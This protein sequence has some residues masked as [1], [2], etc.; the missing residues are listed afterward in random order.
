[1]KKR[2]TGILFFLLLGAGATQAM[3]KDPVPDKVKQ[4]LQKDFEKPLHIDWMHLKDKNLYHARFQYNGET[5]EAFYNEEGNLISTARFIKENQLPIII[6]KEMAENY[7]NYSVREIVEFTN[8]VQ[9]SYIVSAFNSKEMVV[10]KYYT[11][12]DSQRIKRIRNK[13]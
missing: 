7:P 13:S 12:G 6:M 8:E 1:M 11:N 4:S 10:V 2:L 3:D 5:V 9:T